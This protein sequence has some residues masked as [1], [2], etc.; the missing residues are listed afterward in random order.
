MPK[1]TTNTDISIN[2]NKLEITKLIT[3][4]VGRNEL[5]KIPLHDLIFLDNFQVCFKIFIYLVYGESNK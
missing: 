5:T 1:I 3:V 4:E 2:L